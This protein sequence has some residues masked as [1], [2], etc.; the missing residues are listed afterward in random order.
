M[1]HESR[2]YLL[3]VDLGPTSVGWCRV[4][5]DGPLGDR[6]PSP[7]AVLNAGVRIFEAPVSGDI[8]A[9]KDESNARERRLARLAR[10][11]TYRRAVRIRQVWKRLQQHGL[12]PVCDLGSPQARHEALVALDKQLG[13]GADMSH[14][15]R[16]ILPYF[17]RA[18]ALDH[19]LEPFELG[20]VFLHLAQRRGYQSNAKL[21]KKADKKELG[22]VETGINAIKS[23]MEATGART[24][25][26]LFSRH[27]PA[28][29]RIRKNYTSRQMYKD[30]FEKIWE[31][32]MPHHPELLT[33]KLKRRLFKDLF[34]Q[35]PLKSAKKFVGTCQV[36]PRLRRAPLASPPVQRFRL[37]Q[38]V[39]NLRITHKDTGEERRLNEKERERLL[40][41]LDAV[42]DL[43]FAKARKALGLEKAWEFN[44][45]HEGK[46]KL[47][48]N[49][50]E[51]KLR[52][53]F[54]ERW[55]QFSPA[56]REAIIHD[57]RSFQRMDK[58][59]R[60]GEKR[61]GL[62]RVESE[63]FA[64]LAAELEDDYAAFSAK[65]IKMLLPHLEAGLS[66]TEARM[67]AFG[68][69]PAPAAEDLLP[70]VRQAFGD[71]RNPVVERA[72]TELRG[73]VNAVVKRFGKPERI[74][75]ELARDMKNPRARR[76]ELHAQ[77]SIRAELRKSAKERLESQ[78][79]EANRR[80]VEKL[81]LADECG[82]RCPYT[83]LS[84]GMAGSSASILSSTWSIIPF[85]R[86]L[87]NSFA[88]KTICQVEYNRNRKRNQ[89][90]FE[91]EGGDPE[92]WEAMLKRVRGF[93]GV[94]RVYVKKVRDGYVRKTVKE[95][96]RK[97]QR[98]A[99][100]SLESFEDFSSRQLNDTRYISRVAAQYLQRLYG[101][102]TE[103]MKRM[104]VQTCKGQITAYLRDV[105]G[106]NRILGD[107]GEKTRADH[108][109]HAVD[110]VAVAFADARTVKMLSDAAKYGDGRGRLGWLPKCEPP[111]HGFYEEVK[112]TIDKIVVSHRVDRRVSGPLHEQTHYS[113][114][115]KDEKGKS[116]C[117]YRI[118]ITK[119]SD[120]NLDAIVDGRVREVVR[121][122]IAELGGGEPAKLFQDEA[123]LPHLPNK[124]GDPVPIRRVRIRA[125]VNPM[126]VGGG[127]TER[128]V[129]TKENHHVEVFQRADGSMGWA[130]VDMLEAYRRKKAKQPI[131]KTDHGPGTKFV[132][133]LAGGDVVEMQIPAKRGES[134]WAARKLVRSI[135]ISAREMEFSLLTDARKASDRK[136]ERIRIQSEKA[137]KQCAPKKVCI[138]RLGLLVRDAHD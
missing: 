136:A 113:P 28:Q 30:E 92:R 27:N 109:H 63:Q 9:G 99:L 91:T 42:G 80:N 96:N 62:S 106:L 88:N 103:D 50:T 68:D 5:L 20:R 31:A 59:A 52:A 114:P 21:D 110:A 137:L 126:K 29:R 44:L 57:L 122:K 2:P 104:R 58:L 101:P 51:A 22:A 35:R 60:R 105:W 14:P 87:D 26:E 11:Q 108:R 94:E 75:V 41:E 111:W 32:Q 16:N 116:F 43:T 125:S 4:A 61:W 134:T 98:F 3:A 69:L 40:F 56:E 72:L 129:T 85:S 48:G 89:T 128:F 112:A 79:I 131:V 83:G 123:N 6:A 100:T 84:F 135:G 130:L 64:K 19:R 10:R 97:W 102:P 55:R 7:V 37:L 25:G 107:G 33:P 47:I 13:E 74:R 121:A 115:R 67:A 124:H 133:S 54:N 90:P 34:F 81:L 118:P 71:L 93:M 77:N 49:R 65:A 46:D 73:V 39:N 1:S 82:W 138:D 8:E 86:C 95:A 127:P 70:S 76:M 78:G 45:E 38:E 119:L 117:V 18:R 36:F 12:T 17:L 23:E 53:F 66:V 15:R 120:K 132:F 24:L